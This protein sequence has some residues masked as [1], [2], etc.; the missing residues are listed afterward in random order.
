M[1]DVR[2]PGL[3]RLSVVSVLICVLPLA[4][5]QSSSDPSA[6]SGAASNSPT[7]NPPHIQFTSPSLVLTK[8]LA[9]ALVTPKNTGDAITSC[10]SADPLPQGL[11]LQSDCSVSGTPT[12]VTAAKGYVFTANNTGGTSTTTL[13]IVVNDTQPSA[14]SYSN[15]LAVFTKGTAT[16]PDS[17]SDSGGGIT[18]YSINPALPAGLNFNTTS[19]IISGTP[20]ALSI[21][22]PYTITGTN[23]G[24]SVS[25]IISIVVNDVAP[26]NL[27]Y[28]MPTATYSRGTAISPNNPSSLG[29]PVVS[30]SAAS[31]PPGLA[32]NP[33]TGVISGTPLTFSG[34]TNYVVVATNSGGSTSATLKLTVNDIA[35]AALAY[36]Q[37]PVT[38]SMGLNI[39]LNPISHN[40]GGAITQFT[41]SGLPPGLFIDGS[42]TIQGNPTYTT[43][44]PATAV[45]IGTNSGGSASVSVSISVV[46]FAYT[47][48]Q[49][50]WQ[51]GQIITPL[52]PQNS[53]SASVAY[54]ISSALP[55]GLTFDTS[56]GVISGTPTAY[57]EPKSYTVTATAGGSV[58]TQLKLGV[59]GWT[60][61]LTSNAFHL[62]SSA[63][64]YDAP[65]K[66]LDGRVLITGWNYANPIVEN[67]V[68]IYD[69][70]TNSLTQIP[71]TISNFTLF[72]T[73][74]LLSDG[75]VL[76]AD[77]QNGY[78]FDPIANTFSSAIPF[79]QPRTSYQATA[80]Q[81]GKVLLTGG[82]S[83]SNN[84]AL[85]SAELLD[86]TAKSTT[87]IP[88]GMMVPRMNHTTTLLGD[89]KVLIAG[90]QDNSSGTTIET[91]VSEL[92]DPSSNTFT[93][94]A[95]VMPCAVAYHTATLLGSH[96]V[97]AA[98]GV[99][100]NKTPSSYP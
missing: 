38:Y 85:S 49:V 75:T 2:A 45:I 16:S 64:G 13:Y 61:A 74:T 95:G 28:S 82:L 11:T 8:G 50:D 93:S 51:I 79:Q 24:G 67:L 37:N 56:T 84:L 68:Y 70:A 94:T 66:L 36:T 27:A 90:G 18:S 97:V 72:A 48:S 31:L 98:G 20:T 26:S 99:T 77:Y 73:T 80:L 60:V 91:N 6:G 54:S 14:L 52:G 23:T 29:G 4:A 87:L 96:T 5:C 59:S 40:S 65:V 46:N 35:P 71:N 39:S 81:N 21:L 30:Y 86:P 19:G 32:L 12:A 3:R 55:A 57:S 34:A 7:I 63:G 89:G 78:I 43:L 17:P 69:P 33:T 83:F 10:T 41:C 1:R 42:G 88:G 15:P 25:V 22:S 47:A 62:N 44:T 58:S 92:F 53:N 9:F 76:L 100:N